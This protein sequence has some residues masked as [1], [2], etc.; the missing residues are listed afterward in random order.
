MN[1]EV[2]RTI[3][4]APRRWRMRQWP[5]D[6]TVAHLV[7]LDHLDVPSPDDLARA[8]EHARRRGARAV[9]TSAM[10][11]RA[12]EAVLACGFHRL[13]EL[14]L[15][16]RACNG[17]LP[18]PTRSPRALR[19]WHLPAA[20]RVDREAFGPMWGN[21]PASLR[22]IR[23]ATPRHRARRITVGRELAAFSISG[24][25]ADHG[26]LQRLAVATDQRRRGLARD[27]V[28]DALGWMRQLRLTAALVNTG[29]DNHGALA[30]YDQIGFQRLDDVL[31]IAEIRLER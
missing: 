1:G 8:L 9:R 27:L 21:D 2:V 25:A 10:F 13:D 11:P 12:A 17:D 20:A 15:L 23:T 6:A 26:Y 30:L 24:A 28:L 3:D 22:D 16:R 7:F 18:E 14:A 31:T 5:N 4:G 19:P 29:L